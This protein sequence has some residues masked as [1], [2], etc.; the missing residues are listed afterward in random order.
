MF[1]KGDKI[2]LH[3]GTA[4]V[5][6]RAGLPPRS[7]GRRRKGTGEVATVRGFVRGCL[8][9]CLT[10]E[11]QM[12]DWH[13]NTIT[14]YGHSEIIRNF[15]QLAGSLP[16]QWFGIG[17]AASSGASSTNLS[18]CTVIE[19]EYGLQSNSTYNAA[20]GSRAAVAA[21]Q[22]ISGVWTLTQSY[23]YASSHLT[24]G[25]TVGAL[26]QYGVSTVGGGSAMSIALFASSTKG[27]TQA[28]NVTY[29]WSFGT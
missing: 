11:E 21:N 29:N 17:L 23:Q 5:M 26:A 7:G 20:G 19:S 14:T 9:D 16:A 27:T 25:A 10:G 18:T 1:Q 28:L 8:V 6:K 2:I 3:D 22:G 24:N 13:E 4:H 12:G 15:V